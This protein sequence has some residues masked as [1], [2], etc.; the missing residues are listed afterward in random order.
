MICLSSLPLSTAFPEGYKTYVGERGKAQL[1]GGERQRI[2][3]ARALVKQPPILVL[4]EATSSLD[5]ESERLG[6]FL[7]GR[8]GGREGGREEGGRGFLGYFCLVPCP[9]SRSLPFVLFPLSLSPLFSSCASARGF[10]KGDE[11]EDNRGCGASVR[12]GGRETGRERR[13]DGMD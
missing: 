6:G 1:S 4:D 5:P 3:L 7:R 13:I 11:G 2:T 9:C 12:E 8:E 10:G